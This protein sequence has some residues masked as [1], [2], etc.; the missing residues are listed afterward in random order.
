MAIRT[1]EGPASGNCHGGEDEDG[2]GMTAR[3]RAYAI[4]ANLIHA[5][6]LAGPSDSPEA[7]IELVRIRDAMVGAARPDTGPLTEG[8]PDYCE[9]HGLVFVRTI[10][11][12]GRT[13]PLRQCQAC[14]N[15]AARRTQPH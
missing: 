1:G 13:E 11:G 4:V 5:Y 14:I 12:E 15:E 3:K 10:I 7:L 8:G 6:E 9:A 2:G